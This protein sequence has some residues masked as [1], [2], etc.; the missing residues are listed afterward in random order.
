MDP[1]E[2]NLQG[3]LMVLC[4][5]IYLKKLYSLYVYGLFILCNLLCLKGNARTHRQRCARRDNG[6]VLYVVTVV[7]SNCCQCLLNK[8]IKKKTMIA[9]ACAYVHACSV[10]VC[11]YLYI[12]CIRTG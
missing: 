6:R 9:P 3:V 5:C 10:Y 11:T 1:I 7:C 2:R 8:Y 4:L 12:H